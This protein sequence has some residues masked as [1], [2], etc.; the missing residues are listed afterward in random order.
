MANDTG[1]QQWPIV[2]L[3]FPEA[4]LPLYA[5]SSYCARR[6]EP[7]IFHLVLL[8]FLPTPLAPKSWWPPNLDLCAPE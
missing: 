4:F 1:D 7:C 3:T 6:L 8:F 5:P 2:T